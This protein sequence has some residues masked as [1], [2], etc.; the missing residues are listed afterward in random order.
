MTARSK[1]LATAPRPDGSTALSLRAL[2]GPVRHHSSPHE[3]SKRRF[4]QHTVPSQDRPSRIAAA[5]AW[6]ARTGRP[7]P[8]HMRFR[9][10]AAPAA[11]LSSR[12]RLARYAACNGDDAMF[13]CENNLLPPEGE[14]YAARRITP[15]QAR[16][17][18]HKHGRPEARLFGAD[19]AVPAG[20]RRP[21]TPAQ[22]RR[23]RKNAAQQARHQ[24]RQPEFG[25]TGL[26]R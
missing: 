23:F 14:K 2:F 10:P 17:L 7:V 11:P 4:T 1:P 19:R 16:R 24:N 15:A 3:G 22:L 26:P 21:F 20:S 6:S 18:R 12:Q 25:I 13:I 8:P 9:E 5:L